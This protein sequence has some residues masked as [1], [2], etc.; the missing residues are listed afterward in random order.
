VSAD[1]QL[2]H[3]LLCDIAAGNVQLQLDEAVRAVTEAGL[4]V[5]VAAG[6][7]DMDA[8]DS[9]P[10]REATAVTVA[11][12]NEGDQRLWLAKGVWCP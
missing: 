9:S 5:V 11:A 2:A 8:C 12:S 10:A 3:N 4:H 7:E 6:N 1:A